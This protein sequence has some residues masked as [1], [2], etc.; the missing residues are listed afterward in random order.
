MHWSLYILIGAIINVVINW[1]YKAM[2]GKADMFLVSAVVYFTGAIGFFVI[3]AFK[4]HYPQQL[5][6]NGNLIL[7]VLMGLGCVATMFFFLNAI[8]KGP[9]SLVDPMW[10]CVYALASA[11]IG[12]CIL[13][14]HP[15]PVALAGVAIYIVGAFLMARG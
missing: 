12:M 10:A 2:N 15:S 5:L 13:K 1:G 11:I 8:T 4:G 9:I 7:P 6:A 14:E 3:S